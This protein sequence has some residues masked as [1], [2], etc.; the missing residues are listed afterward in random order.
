LAHNLQYR[1][2]PAKAKVEAAVQKLKE[3]IAEMDKLNLYL[4]KRTEAGTGDEEIE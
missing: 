3:V 2:G 4:P 1:R